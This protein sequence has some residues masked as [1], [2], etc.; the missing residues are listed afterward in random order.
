VRAAIVA[1]LLV[2][3]SREATREEVREEAFSPPKPVPIE[4]HCRSGAGGECHWNN[5]T[6]LAGC[7]TMSD[8]YCRVSSQP[9]WQW[10]CYVTESECYN[11]KTAREDCSLRKAN[12]PRFYAR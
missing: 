11:H 2:A 12:D 3:C 1:L 7:F 10:A 9:P 4:F 6:E 8:A 5:C